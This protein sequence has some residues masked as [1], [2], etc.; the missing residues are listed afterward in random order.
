ME[1]EE[2]KEKQ[3]KALYFMC[4]LILL[5]LIGLWVWFS[6]EELLVKSIIGFAIF[7]LIDTCWRFRK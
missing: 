3:K 7:T 1:K 5:F 2:L 4:H 6:P